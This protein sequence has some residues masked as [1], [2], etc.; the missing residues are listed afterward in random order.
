M[1]QNKS[2][3][4]CVKKDD[5]TSFN[6]NQHKNMN[7]KNLILSILL[8]QIAPFAGKAQREIVA[9]LQA[10]NG[11]P[12]FFAKLK[13]KQPLTIVYFGGSI[14]NHPGYRVYSEEW[15]KTQYPQNKFTTVNAGIGGTGS[16]LGVFRMDQDVLY[17][18]PDLVF[19]EFAVNDAGTDSLIICHSMEGI[20]RKIRKHNPKIDICFL[21]TVNQGMLND[22]MQGRL[23]KSMR[24]MENIA[25]YYDIPSVN[26]AMKVIDLVK[27]DSLIFKGD[28]GKDYGSK[29]VFSDDG[30]HP[31]FE[32]GHKIYTQTLTHSMLAMEKI[33]T[34]KAE[35][36]LKLPLYPDNFERAKSVSLSTFYIS[37]GWKNVS[38]DDK[39]YNYYQGS[40]KVFPDLISSENPDD[41]IEIKFKG[42]VAGLFD[43]IG[44][45]SAGFTVEVDGREKSAYRR[46][47][48]Y[49]GNVF[50]SNYQLLPVMKEGIH[51]LIIRPDNT[52][53]D[54]KIIYDSKPSQIK[55]STYFQSF[56]TY[57][58]KIILIGEVLK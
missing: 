41:F 22:L 26:F 56:N 46:F 12:N 50:R 23:Y 37:N 21:Y 18:Y 19:V 25:K 47:D 8:L 34:G 15:F 40:S 5:H 42:T 39:I 17:H 54:K 58:G 24:Y 28:K 38:S 36:E 48:V 51:T 6:K 11:C 20:V 33:K 43:V 35:K 30:T 31:S 4:Q 29:K 27:K 3:K 16:D 9:G 32:V 13:A 7:F 10:R 55:D 1:E 57:I 49:C 53:F 52:R 44:P 2:K 45:S 14:T